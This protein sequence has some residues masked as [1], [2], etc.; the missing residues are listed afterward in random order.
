MTALPD[1]WLRSDVRS[2]FV[3]TDD[4]QQL[5]WRTVGSGPPLACCNGVGVS[6]FFWK[7]IVEHFRPHFQVILWDYRGHGRSTVPAD[8]D[9]TDMTMERN[10]RDLL[11]VLDAVGAREP[12]ILL[13]HSM[14]CQVILEA[15]HQAPERVRALV[16]MFGTFGRALDTFM[17]L[18]N[19][20]S[21]FE[22]IRGFA[23]KADRSS[24]RLLLPLY[25]S[26]V[27]FDFSRITGLVDRYYATQT[28]VDRYTDHLVHMNPDV[29]LRMVGQMADHD[30]TDH[31]PN[32]KVP[33]LVFGGER[34]LFTPLHRSRKMVELIP[35][36]ELTILAEGSHAAIVEHPET[37]NL[38]LDRFLRERCG[39]SPIP[40]T[41]IRQAAAQR[42]AR[43]A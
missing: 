31:L 16:P 42:S 6:T 34:D 8:I 27:A 17:D 2:G 35:G 37:I 10:A 24:K 32:I 41:P 29:F 4:G 3:R 19:A 22:R 38:R 39:W 43:G 7:Y 26:P 36:A 25:A 13:G 5:Y 12:A 9:A 20:R 33:T 1:A 15:H 30:L 14:G 21:W 11:T 40:A 23:S 18:K 28:D